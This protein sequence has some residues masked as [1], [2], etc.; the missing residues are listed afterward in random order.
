MFVVVLVSLSKA[1]SLICF[2]PPKCINGTCEVV[3]IKYVTVKAKSAIQQPGMYAPKGVEK[4]I[5]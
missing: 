2:S 3:K 4:D 1:L 5:E